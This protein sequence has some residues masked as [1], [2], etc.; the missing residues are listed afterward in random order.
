MFGMDFSQICNKNI[1]IDYFNNKKLKKKIL[2]M[3]KFNS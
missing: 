2:R 3:T 1:L